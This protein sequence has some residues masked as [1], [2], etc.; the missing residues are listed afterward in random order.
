MP[1]TGDRKP[2]PIVS[3]PFVE[4]EPQFSP[5]GRWLAYYSNETGRNEVFGTAVPDDRGQMANLQ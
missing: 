5:D 4:G 2:I 1:L 3:T